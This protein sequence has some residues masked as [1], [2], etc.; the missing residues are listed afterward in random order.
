[1]RGL[2]NFIVELTSIIATA[3][4]AL[5]LLASHLLPHLLLRLLLILLL[6]LEGKIL[7]EDNAK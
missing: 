1:M 2:P 7:L 3:M 4:E 5:L 6:L